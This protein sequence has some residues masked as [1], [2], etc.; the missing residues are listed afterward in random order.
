[1]KMTTSNIDEDKL[2]SDQVQRF[3]QHIPPLTLTKG[4]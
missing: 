1:M 2:K 4:Y 3:T